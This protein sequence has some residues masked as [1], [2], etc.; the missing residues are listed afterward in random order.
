MLTLNFCLTCRYLFWV[1]Y[2]AGFWFHW[3]NALWVWFVLFCWFGVFRVWLFYELLVLFSL[4]MLDCFWVG[5][6]VV[7]YV[8]G[9]WV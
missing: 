9:W 2:L 6:V 7:F 5:V 1:L 3:C 8:F 4:A